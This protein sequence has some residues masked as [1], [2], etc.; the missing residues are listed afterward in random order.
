MRQYQHCEL[1]GYNYIGMV[2]SEWINSVSLHRLSII[3]ARHVRS[4]TQIVGSFTYIVRILQTWLVRVTW[5]QQSVWRINRRKWKADYA[6]PPSRN[7]SASLADWYSSQH[8]K[9]WFR[10]VTRLNLFSC[11]HYF[12]Q[13]NYIIL[14]HEHKLFSHKQYRLTAET[15]KLHDRLYRLCCK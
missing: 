15:A 6:I 4:I 13:H 7:V 12:V 5:R 8:F 2:G 10:N 9:L 14:S 3:W 1:D 11:W